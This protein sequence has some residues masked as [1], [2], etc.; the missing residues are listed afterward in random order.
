[1]V[2]KWTPDCTMKTPS[3]YAPPGPNCEGGNVTGE[4]MNKGYTP[5]AAPMSQGA[6][7]RVK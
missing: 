3:T 7:K 1:M 4:M 6:M 2:K 5:I